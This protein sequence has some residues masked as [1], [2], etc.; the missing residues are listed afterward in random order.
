MFRR[1]G[2]ILATAVLVTS[3]HADVVACGD[4]FLQIG[5]SV[6]LWH[7][8]S[9]YPASILVFAPGWTGRG[10][11]AFEAMLRRAGHTPLTVTSERGLE[12]ALAGAK[13]EVVI[14]AYARAGAARKALLAASSTAALLPVLTKPAKSQEAEARAAYPILL[15]PEKMTDVEAMEALD[16]LIESV[17]KELGA[18]AP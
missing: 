18:P 2:L 11:N 3:A 4:K 16:R 13:Y 7:Y 10:V 5:R 8:N 1:V 12:L 14:T 17:R 15:R 9:V 6:R